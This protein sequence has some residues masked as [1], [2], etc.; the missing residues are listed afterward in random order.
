LEKGL[1]DLDSLGKWL[2]KWRW[3]WWFYCISSSWYDWA[4]VI[5]CLFQRED[6]L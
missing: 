4:N 5:C 2:W 3:W 6:L 1:A